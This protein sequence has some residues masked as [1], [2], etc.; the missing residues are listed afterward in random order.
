MKD[1]PESFFS[2][3]TSWINKQFETTVKDAIGKNAN[4]D[5]YVLQPIANEIKKGRPV[6]G[7]VEV[8]QYGQMN[9][10][11]NQNN[12]KLYFQPNLKQVQNKK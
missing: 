8:D 12:Q 7:I 2:G 1:A 4:L 6:Y 10:V 5:N 9:A 11:L 3:D